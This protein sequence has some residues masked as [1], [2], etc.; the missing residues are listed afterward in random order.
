MSPY[1]RAV[2]VAGLL[3]AG[4]T[5]QAATAPSTRV[6]PEAGQ[7]RTVFHVTYHAIGS[8]GY[9]GEY[10]VLYGPRGT[11]CAGRRAQQPIFNADERKLRLF[12]GPDVYDRVQDG[13][14]RELVDIREFGPRRWCR[15]AW[16]GSVIYL[17]ECD[18]IPSPRVTFRFRV[19]RTSEN[20]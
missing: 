1:R 2:I 13:P 4:P 6:Y 10:L 16:R 8:D 17:S 15:G 3:F 12:F 9:D 14:G 7:A 5:A 19:Y 20:P 11:P 18:C